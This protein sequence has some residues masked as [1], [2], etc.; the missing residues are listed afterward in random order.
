MTTAAV[1]TEALDGDVVHAR[2]HAVLVRDLLPEHLD[3]SSTD[4]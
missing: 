4:R 2:T 1:E 3:G